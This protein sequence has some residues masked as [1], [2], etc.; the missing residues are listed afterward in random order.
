MSDQTKDRLEGTMDDLKGRG[1]EAWGDLT[2]DEDKQAEGE[3]DQAKGKTKQGMADLK[4][5]LDDKVKDLT[6]R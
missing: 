4:E 2:N 1:K 5:K 3:L 6:D